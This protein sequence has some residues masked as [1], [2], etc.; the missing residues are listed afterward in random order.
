MGAILKKLLLIVQ[1]ATPSQ[2]IALS[3]FTEVHL[4]MI[5]GLFQ[6]SS[7]KLNSTL[8]QAILYS[9]S[10]RISGESVRL[11]TAAHQQSVQGKALSDKES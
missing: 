10:V 2:C 8:L 5:T 9:T 4:G 11:K 7:D 6:A 1:V 3:V